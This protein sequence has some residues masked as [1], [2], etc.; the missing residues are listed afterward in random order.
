MNKF[1]N[2]GAG[3]RFF[4]VLPYKCF[5]VIITG[6]ARTIKPLQ[7]YIL[8]NCKFPWIVQLCEVRLRHNK[9][10]CFIHLGTAV[11][12]IHSRDISATLSKFRAKTRSRLVADRV[13]K[14]TAIDPSKEPPRSLKGPSYS[15]QNLNHLKDNGK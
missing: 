4:E 10:R 13:F 1:Y 8:K 12:S 7:N 9:N 15:L 11:L 14:R 5:I 6:N 3:S 2:L